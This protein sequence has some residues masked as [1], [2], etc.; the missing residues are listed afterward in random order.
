MA[1]REVERLFLGRV[2][3]RQHEQRATGVFPSKAPAPSATAVPIGSYVAGG[4]A[5]VA[6]GVFTYASIK[7]ASDRSS[8]HCDRGCSDAD[9]DHVRKEYLVADVALGIGLVSVGVGL[10]LWLLTDGGAPSSRAAASAHV[11]DRD[12]IRWK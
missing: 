12:R 10:A 1:R 5:V 6:L 7:G 8:L 4:I 9:Y 2:A 3:P 11:R